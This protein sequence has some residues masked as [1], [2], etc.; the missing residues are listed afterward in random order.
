MELYDYTGVM[1]FHSSY[2]FDGRVSIE[3]IIKAA[4]ENGIDF[5]MLTDH[6]TLGARRDGLE[7]WNGG[8]LL[9]V[10]QEISPRF[11]HYLAFGIDEELIVDEN[12]I[13]YR[14]QDCIDRVNA[15]GGVG[16]IAHP[17]HAGT[18]KFHVKHFPWRDWSVSG[19]TGMGIWD[20]MTDWQSTLTNLPGALIAYLFPAY[21]LKGPRKITLKR[22]D[23]L[24]K[25]GRI[26]GI[27]ELDNHDTPRKLLGMTVGIF[28]FKRAFRFIRTHLLLDNPLKGEAEEDMTVLLNALKNG[29][30]YIAMEYFRDAKGFSV[31]LSDLNREVT[32]GDEFSLKGEAFLNV[33][34]P[35]RGKIR[36]I[37][38]GG[39]VAETVG[40]KIMYKISQEGVYRA[41]AYLK[42]WG[43]YRPW[44]FSNPVH[45]R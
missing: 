15:L 32:M 10:G 39:V 25:K 4:G 34:I 22:W 19:Y 44:I 1:H 5:L 8:I 42:V 7:G 23:H 11:N 38:D 27:G 21:V 13:G 9:V 16:F 35:E 12:D 14:P 43:K 26:V 36:I 30:A 6:S 28:P 45:V 20:F 31:L 29:R 18:E 37:Q 24:N 2:S 33:K 40:K 17:D 3:E 41:E